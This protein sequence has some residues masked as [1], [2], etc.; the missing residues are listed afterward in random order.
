MAEA[1]IKSI[2]YRFALQSS[3]KVNETPTF[4]KDKKLL[5]I[6][7]VLNENDKNALTSALGQAG[8]SPLTNIK[9][10]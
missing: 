1:T 8:A 10:Q 6:D 2:L 4:L 5:R 7:H 9:T 3:G